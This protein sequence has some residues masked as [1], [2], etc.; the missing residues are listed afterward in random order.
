[1]EGI[2]LSD[3][4]AMYL[5]MSGMPDPNGTVQQQQTATQTN[6]TQEQTPAQQ[7]EE[8]PQVP[9]TQEP[10]PQA[11]STP[12]PAPSQNDWLKNYVEATGHTVQSADEIKEAL[13]FRNKYQ[14]LNSRYSDLEAKSKVSPYANDLVKTLNELYANGAKPEEVKTFLELQNTDTTINGIDDYVSKGER[15]IKLRMAYEKPFLTPN[16]VEGLYNKQFGDLDHD[17]AIAMAEFKSAAHDAKT[18]I[19]AKKVSA[20]QPESILQFKQT[21]EQKAQ[22][23]ANVKSYVGSVKGIEHPFEFKNGDEK[24]TLRFKATTEQE[25]AIQQVLQNILISRN[26]A[27]IQDNVQKINEAYSEAFWRVC[28]QSAVDAA[29]RHA[30]AEATKAVY[31]KVNSV[32]SATPAPAAAPANVPDAREAA[33]QAWLARYGN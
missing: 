27:P 30:K 12:P 9:Q 26:I 22:F 8:P 10:A 29:Y 7:A 25:N 24:D 32:P 13:E 15:F 11:E 23:E 6:T 1:M 31:E 17:D 28:G 16:E 18:F 3:A 4:R 20:A 33:R 5:Q 19:D 2:P 14:E 21:A